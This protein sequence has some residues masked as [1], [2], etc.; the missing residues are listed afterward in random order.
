MEQASQDVEREAATTLSKRQRGCPSFLE[1]LQQRATGTTPCRFFERHV[2]RSHALLS[3]LSKLTTLE[4]HA[5]CVNT[6][7]WSKEG[8]LLASGSDDCRVCLWSCWNAGHA[9][10]KGAVATGHRRNIFSVAF[11][12]ET[13]NAQFVSCALDKHV[14]LVDVESGNSTLLAHTRQFCSK[15]AFVPY[16]TSCFLTA[17][18]DGRITLFDVRQAANY[19]PA[20]NL[21]AIG[22][23]T[24]L[25]FD[26]TTGG[27]HFAVGC[28]D[29]L[30]RVY[31]LRC[32]N[33]VDP[34]STAVSFQYVPRSLLPGKR[35]RGPYE[36]M[37]SGASSVCYSSNGELLVNMRGAELYRFD[38]MRNALAAQPAEGAMGTLVGDADRGPMGMAHEAAEATAAATAEA[39]AEATV[40]EATAAE[41]TAAVVAGDGTCPMDAA[42]THFER[43]RHAAS[44]QPS[45]APL[46]PDTTSPPSPLSSSAI[47]APPKEST[48]LHMLDGVPTLTHVLTEYRGRVN[49]E[50]FAKEA[51]FLY[52]DSY[53]ATG[54]DRGTGS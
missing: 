12:P 37:A 41:A 50:T 45:S 25:A 20:V 51:C 29:P 8:D 33:F 24:A 7:H 34:K 3:R 36:C 53:V 49:E 43:S 39:T 22:S 14:R 4:E 38:S 52:D 35:R 42:V 6:L 5:G 23:C 13:A 28:D 46:A 54:G 19:K 17:G 31:D 21:S 40:A 26:P 30:V 2:W 15:L 27:H 32:V 9:A 11:V 1:R 18:Q 47:V 44:M 16:S 48:P 10:L